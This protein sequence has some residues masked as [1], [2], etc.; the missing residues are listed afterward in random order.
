MINWQP[1]A[2]AKQDGTPYLLWIPKTNLP[3]TF[4][5]IEPG[6]AIQ[7]SYFQAPYEGGDDGWETC[8]GTIGE[9]TLFA[10]VNFP[11]D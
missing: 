9:P 2:E 8:I 11:D 10:E 1:I 3:E 4:E 5:V 7:G 6:I